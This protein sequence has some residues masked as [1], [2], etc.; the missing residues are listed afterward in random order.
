MRS[1]FGLAQAPPIRGAIVIGGD[2]IALGAVRSLGRQGLPVWVLVGEHRVA[3]T[4]RYCT[5]TDRKSTRLN[6]SH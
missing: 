2:R 3:T 6:S 1:T 4:S 5:R